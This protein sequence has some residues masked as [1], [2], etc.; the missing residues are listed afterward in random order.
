MPLPLHLGAEGRLSF[1]KVTTPRHEEKMGPVGSRGRA[2]VVLVI[3]TSIVALGGCSSRSAAQKVYLVSQSSSLGR[4]TQGEGGGDGNAPFD[5]LRAESWDR[6]N[7]DEQAWA[8]VLG[9]QISSKPKVPPADL[10]VTVKARFEMLRGSRAALRPTV[11]AYQQDAKSIAKALKAGFDVYVG[12]L[13]TKGAPYVGSALAVDKIGKLAWLGEC[14]ARDSNSTAASLERA[15]VN[16]KRVG[17]A[18]RRWFAD[19]NT[20][21]LLRALAGA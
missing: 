9:W 4:C 2:G 5:P 21:A 17:P 1:G 14:A 16:P 10:T 20:R 6:R 3:V 7:A 8:R 18:V 11:G 12:A 19:G 15:N 13:R